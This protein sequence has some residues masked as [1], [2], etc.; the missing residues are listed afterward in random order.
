VTGNPTLA[1]NAS[2]IEGIKVRITAKA[3]ATRRRRRPAGGGEE[4]LGRC[5]GRLVF[6]ATRR[7]WSTPSARLLQSAGLTLGLAESVTG[8]LVA[9]RCTEVPGSSAWFR[10]GWCPTTAP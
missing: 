4:Q 10:G 5:S 1:F 3:A 7:P 2:G 8:G 6:G 9:S